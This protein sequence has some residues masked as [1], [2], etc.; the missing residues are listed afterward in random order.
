LTNRTDLEKKIVTELDEV[1]F[2]LGD[3]TEFDENMFWFLLSVNH[4]KQW[5]VK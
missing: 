2:L 5:F 3:E 1:Q 4:S